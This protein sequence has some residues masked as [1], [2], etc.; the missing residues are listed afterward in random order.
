MRE[1]KVRFHRQAAVN[2]SENEKVS[3][4]E[5]SGEGAFRLSWDSISLDGYW[6]L[7]DVDG[8]LGRIGGL[9]G[10]LVLRPHLLK[11][12]SESIRV[13]DLRRLRILHEK[14]AAIIH[15]YHDRTP[16]EMEVHVFSVGEDS[17]P[18]VLESIRAVVPAKLLHERTVR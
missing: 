3:L 13:A 10:K 17:A 16:E 6:R 9:L 7:S 18:D 4:W 2:L 14:S 15:I 5:P 12:R 11:E 8:V 1:F